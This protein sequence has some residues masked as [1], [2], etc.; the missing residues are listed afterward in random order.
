MKYA[1]RNGQPTTKYNKFISS[2]RKKYR[3][4]IIEFLVV[5]LL[6]AVW[7]TVARVTFDHLVGRFKAGVGDLCDRELLM[8]CLLGGDYWCI[9]R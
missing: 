3:D 2:H 8:I 9:S 5:C 4:F 7:P 6:V 1:W